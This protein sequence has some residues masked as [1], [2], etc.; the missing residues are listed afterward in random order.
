MQSLTHIASSSTTA[1]CHYR[2][3]TTTIL[4]TTSA[5]TVTP[6]INTKNEAAHV[7]PSP[8]HSCSS[9][10]PYD[11]VNQSPWVLDTVNDTVASSSTKNS[12]PRCLDWKPK[13][14]PL[15]KWISAVRPSQLSSTDCEWIGIQCNKNGSGGSA[16]S[17]NGFGQH[18]MVS[19]P[20]CRRALRLITNQ[21]AN[22]VISPTKSR[23]LAAV[24]KKSNST[25]YIM[26]QKQPPHIAAVT[27]TAMPASKQEEDA[28]LLGKWIF[29]VSTSDADATWERIARATAR[30]ELGSYAKITPAARTTTIA[31][32]VMRNNRS[33]MLSADV[34]PPI[35][36]CVYVQDFT[37][38]DQVK[39]VL[40]MLL[41]LLGNHIRTSFKPEIYG[42]AD[43]VLYK[44]EQVLEWNDA[45]TNDDDGRDQQRKII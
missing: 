1:R 45:T 22:T 15:E 3:T 18:R 35:I 6:I 31:S 8:R 10:F 39:H 19:P 12:I 13:D 34:R 33:S 37:R 21:I 30:G 14:I 23:V 2:P 38:R 9:A 44:K 28:A 26:I 4:T 40:E 29:F 25:N 11:Y 32:S 24:K 16:I 27:T 17:S 7:S 36:C 5:A 41:K 20:A 43:P 42:D